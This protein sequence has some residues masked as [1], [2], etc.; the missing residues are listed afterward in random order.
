MSACKASVL[1]VINIIHPSP[2][3]REHEASIRKGEM[4]LTMCGCLQLTSEARYKYSDVTHCVLTLSRTQTDAILKL[5]YA[6]TFV[7]E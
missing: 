6:F 1:F 3:T 5:N 2:C 7:H 4:S